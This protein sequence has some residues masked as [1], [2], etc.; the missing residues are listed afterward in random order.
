MLRIFFFLAG[1]GTTNDFRPKII[2]GP[3][4]I[5]GKKKKP[6]SGAVPQNGIHFFGC[7]VRRRFFLKFRGFGV[8][9]RG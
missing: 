2:F 3:P 9:A 1:G 8:A 4:Q 5:R 7:S 6:K